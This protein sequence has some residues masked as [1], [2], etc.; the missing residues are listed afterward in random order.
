MPEKLIVSVGNEINYITIQI[1]TH[2]KNEIQVKKYDVIGVHDHCFV[3]NDYSFTTIRIGKEKHHTC[4]NI[5]STWE[6]KWGIAR[7]DDYIRGSVYS[8]QKPRVAFNKV[9]KSISKYIS[10]NYFKYSTLKDVVLNIKF[11]KQTD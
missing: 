11:P 3:I 2:S 10:D 5:P 9:K 4:L 1:D 7:Y 8:I 6:M